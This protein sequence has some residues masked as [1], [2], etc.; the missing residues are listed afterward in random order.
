VPK[1]VLNVEFKLFGSL[2][3]RQFSK[4]LIGSLIALALY[5]SPL[6][7]LISLPLM[8]ISVL[9][10]VGAALVKD[11]EVRLSGLIK[12]LVTSPR[13]VWRK[14]EAVP[15]ALKSK[16]QQQAI[17][18]KGRGKKSSSGPVN[19]PRQ[20]NVDDLS[21]D[22]ILL[23]R[24]I[25]AEDAGLASAEED[26]NFSRV[27]EQQYGVSLDESLQKRKGQQQAPVSQPAVKQTNLAGEGK[28][29]V[30]TVS[31]SGDRVVEIKPLQNNT[32]RE[33]LSPEA[34]AMA[35]QSS[36]NAEVTP[37]Q[38][39]EYKSEINKLRKELSQLNRE[40]TDPARRKDILERINDLYA[41]LGV[42]TDPKP[43]LPV[44]EGLVQEGDLHVIYGV[45]V[46]KQNRPLSASTVTVLDT[47]QQPLGS[48]AITGEDGRFA[49]SIP[50]NQT[51][52]VVTIDREGHKFRPYKIKV[53][54]G[55]L[56][57]YK[58]REH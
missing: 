41:L 24:S 35:G 30:E 28:E 36:D 12:A 52:I 58:F 21:L 50:E 42:K 43:R 10:G 1:N 2:S 23:A 26:P 32:P 54:A 14:Q 18:D 8:I 33:Q 9:V 11:F 6:P 22:Q 38:T 13:Y 53:G 3:V 19:G 51:E 37:E 48:A 4:V 39:T 56:P 17:K 44:S 46:D 34:L 7:I 57:A 55:K 5:L 31:T 47:T 15:A 20:L 25:Y 45:V 40:G 49:M 29:G 16:Q 27:Y